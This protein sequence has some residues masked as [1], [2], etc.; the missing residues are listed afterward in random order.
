MCK[1]APQTYS[2]VQPCSLV[3]R[4]SQLETNCTIKL[5]LG[6][7]CLK[8]TPHSE[9]TICLSSSEFSFVWAQWQPRFTTKLLYFTTK[10]SALLSVHA[11]G[12]SEHNVIN[13]TK[14][15]ENSELSYRNSM[16]HSLRSK[17]ARYYPSRMI[18]VF[19]K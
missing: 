19:E 4:V 15:G 12:A 13:V 18:L 17:Y 10:V 2:N 9:V 6:D 7:F 8:E 5:L 16:V 3:P 1:S 11:Y 14:R